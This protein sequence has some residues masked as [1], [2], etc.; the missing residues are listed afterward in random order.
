MDTLLRSALALHLSAGHELERIPG[1]DLVVAAKYLIP[2]HALLVQGV[3]S[4][5]GIPAVVADHHR[6]Q[7]DLLIAPALGGVRI[8][9]PPS[10][11]AQTAQVLDEFERGVYALGDDADVG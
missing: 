4:A 7:A 2:T 6:A 5:A 3:L 11:L 1:R 8:L 9:V 10:F